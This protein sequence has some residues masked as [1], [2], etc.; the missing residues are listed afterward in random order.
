M[1]QL[2]SI[3]KIL[4]ITSLVAASLIQAEDI[5]DII[6]HKGS[7]GIVRTTGEV[8][9][10]NIGEDIWFKDAIETANGRMKIKFLDET[11]LA[12]TEHT[13]VVIDEYNIC[14]LYTSAAA[15]DS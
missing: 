13:E 2:Q 6:E 14:L 8:L 12:L 15:D 5:G 1:L 10:G 7:S 4:A 11:N 3:K 9:N